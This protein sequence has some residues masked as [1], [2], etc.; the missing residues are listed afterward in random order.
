MSEIANLGEVKKLSLGVK[1]NRAAELFRKFLKS[2]DEQSK[3]PHPLEYMVGVKG[4]DDIKQS[5]GTNGNI[6]VRILEFIVFLLIYKIKNNTIIQN[7]GN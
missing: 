5:G 6:T 7:K 4:K 3:G 1:P 2:G